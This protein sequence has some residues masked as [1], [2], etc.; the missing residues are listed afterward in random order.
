MTTG[1]RSDAGKVNGCVCV[2]VWL[3]ENMCMYGLRKQ[4]Y[5]GLRKT[6]CSLEK[7]LDYADATEN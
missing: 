1:G 3:G 5:R 2:C 4:K 6:G 7:I